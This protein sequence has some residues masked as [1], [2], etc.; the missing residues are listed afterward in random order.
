MCVCVPHF[1]NSSLRANAYVCVNVFELYAC[2]CVRVC[3]YLCVCACI[4]VCVCAR[5]FV[6]ARVCVCVCVCVCV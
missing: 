3:F 5:A 1:C 4:C 6:F 2:N